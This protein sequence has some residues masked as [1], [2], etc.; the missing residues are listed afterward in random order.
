[1]FSFCF[2]F[3]R[4]TTISWVVCL[5]FTEY[6]YIILQQIGWLYNRNLSKQDQF[7]PNIIFCL[8]DPSTQGFAWELNR[9]IE[10]LCNDAEYREE[11]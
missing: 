2:F 1:M 4:I 7:F 10:K 5:V 8:S 3:S 6:F 11:L 9:E